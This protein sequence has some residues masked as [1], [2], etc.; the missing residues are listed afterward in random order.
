MVIDPGV[1]HLKAIMR[2]LLNERGTKSEVLEMTRYTSRG[3]DDSDDDSNHEK[4]RL[5]RCRRKMQAAGSNRVRVS[6]QYVRCEYLHCTGHD[7]SFTT[8]YI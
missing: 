6:L 3:F 4:N 5:L 1:Q 8:S 2:D 7:E